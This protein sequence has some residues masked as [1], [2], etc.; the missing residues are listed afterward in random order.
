MYLHSSFLFFHPWGR[1]CLLFGI[2]T[3][4]RWGCSFS[5]SSW[6]KTAKWALHRVLLVYLGI[7]SGELLPAIPLQPRAEAQ[8]GRGNIVTSLD[9]ATLAPGHY[10]SNYS[11]PT[12]QYRHEAPPQLGTYICRPLLSWSIQAVGIIH[13]LPLRPLPLVYAQVVSIVL[14]CTKALNDILEQS[15]C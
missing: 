7:S 5:L 15:R 14:L 2:A 3:P 9:F 4:W 13:T 8:L 10:A 6:E 11:M 12:L 1:Q